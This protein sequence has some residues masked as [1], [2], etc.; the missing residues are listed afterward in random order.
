MYRII[1]FFAAVM[2][3]AAQ[4]PANPD[5]NSVLQA[6]L[7]E[8]RA[9]RQDLQ[10]SAA[11]IQRVQILMFRVQTEAEFVSRAS[12][13]ADDAHNRCANAQ[14]QRRY[15]TAQV[16]QLEARRSNPQTPADQNLGDQI[17]RLKSNLESMST[18]EQQCTAREIEAGA[19]LKDEQNKMADL[20]DQL[21]KLDKLLAGH[22]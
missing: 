19:Q 18:E 11:T 7:T 8:I 13:R 16:E 2:A 21:D 3:A 22:R 17:T 9:L 14:Q 15:L 6:L 12:Q 5:N 1:W 10:T 20:Q 4:T